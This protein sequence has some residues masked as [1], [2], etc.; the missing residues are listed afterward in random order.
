MVYERCSACVL[1]LGALALVQGNALI[2]VYMSDVALV[3]R[4]SATCSLLASFFLGG[5]LG[6]L[7][8]HF[9]RRLHLLA[10]LKA[11]GTVAGANS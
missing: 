2:M 6:H 10:A 3:Y 11:Q 4:S 7:L 1:Q 9:L 8:G 5:L